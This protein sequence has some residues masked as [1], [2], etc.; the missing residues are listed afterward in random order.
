MCR[1]VAFGTSVT[2]KLFG[3]ITWILTVDITLITFLRLILCCILWT[4]NKNILLHDNKI[5]MIYALDSTKIRIL[6]LKLEK[7]MYDKGPYNRYVSRC[8]DP[9]QL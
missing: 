6:I 4:N 2:A 3:V 9:Y 1:F 5:W 8:G 7:L